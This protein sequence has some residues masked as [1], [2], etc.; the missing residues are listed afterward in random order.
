MAYK[1]AAQ[2]SLGMRPTSTWPSKPKT[3]NKDHLI[4]PQSLKIAQINSWLTVMYALN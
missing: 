3:L 4:E 1:A 2:D